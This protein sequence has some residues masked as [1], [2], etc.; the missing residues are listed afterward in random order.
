ML[1]LPKIA[2]V[3]GGE[4][5]T[6]LAFF[7]AFS[8]A[9]A[10]AAANDPED[11]ICAIPGQYFQKTGSYTIFL[12][13]D[14]NTT[15]WVDGSYLVLLKDKN[16]TDSRGKWPAATVLN[17]TFPVR[18]LRFDTQRADTYFEHNGCFEIGAAGLEL[19]YPGA[20]VAMGRGDGY[21]LAT[22]VKLM[23]NQ[24]WKGPASGNSTAFSFTDDQHI[25]Q[26]NYH[27]DYLS[28]DPS[29]T[30]WTVQGRLAV[31]FCRTN[32]LENVDVRVEDPARIRCR[33]RIRPSDDRIYYAGLHAKSLTL[34]G[35]AE[36][37]Q[38]GGTVS[39]YHSSHASTM[40]P[41]MD[42][43]TMAPLV[44]LEDGADMKLVGAEWDLPLLRVT[45]AGAT[46]SLRGS[47]TFIR[48][49]SAIELQDGA[50]LELPATN[51]ES[52]VS[53][54]FS[55]TG[56]GTLKVASDAKPLTQAYVASFPMHS[57]GW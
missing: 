48:A 39:S 16:T 50:T 46:S 52:G 27:N 12:D 44:I 37:W 42:S 54:G 25:G 32:A 14:G 3:W 33:S 9:A 28:A 30:S 19:T 53:A 57:H 13:R 47:C 36:M 24:V 10:F 56:T 43:I 22:R 29:V 41:L 35:D 51:L 55:V 1:K 21:G 15:N 8:L 18:G 5:R 7:A 38:A 45:G 2:H 26:Y 23:E 6:L 4:Y 40:Q 49:S 34:S 20:C 17:A 31:W 11:T